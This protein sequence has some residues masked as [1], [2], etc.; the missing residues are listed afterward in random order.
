MISADLEAKIRRLFHAEKWPIG[1]IGRH[2]EVHHSTVRRTLRRDGVPL[3]AM[4][5]RTSKIDPFVPFVLET[6]EAFPDLAASVL[7]QMVKGRGYDG[8]PDHFRAIIGRYRPKKAAEAYLR[9]STLPGEQAQ[10]DWGHFGHIEIDGTRRPLVAFVMVLAWSRWMFLRFGV[11]QR[12]G[13]FLGHHAAAFEELGGVPRVVLYDN[14][15]SAVIQR[16]G[17]AIVFNQTLLGFAGHHRYEV[18]PCAPRRGNEK[19]RVERG[20]RDVRESFMPARTWTDLAD[21]NR[22]AEAWCRDVRGARRHPE[23]KTL[24]VH[25]AFLEEKAKLLPLPDDAFPVE[26]RVEVVIGK[27]PYARFD[28]NDYSV[29]HT[30]VR[31][32]VTVVASPDTVR[33]LDSNEEIARHARSWGKGCMVEDP[34]HIEALVVH[35]AKASESR[36]MPRLFTAVPDARRLIEALAERGGNIGGA[37]ARLGELLDAFG[38]EEL[39]V[40]IQEALGADAPHP[41]AV[42]QVLDRRRQDTD[43]PPPIAVTL[44]NDPRVRNVVVPPRTL[45]AY[46]Q[47]AG[48]SGGHNG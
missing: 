31:R 7:Y 22:Q 5:T 48:N 46:D 26:D 14:L 18:R 16:I 19:G 4:L 34:A 35:K 20:I 43:Q 45:H 39:T 30:R 42:R 9:L 44:P 40:A 8:G 1:T 17:K 12:M 47:L 29:P 13:S 28:T 36:G 33:V 23:D 24:T 2:L 38:A 21:L 41:S 25:G 6:L 37:V 10:V 32:A 11:D 15:K 27:T 3:T